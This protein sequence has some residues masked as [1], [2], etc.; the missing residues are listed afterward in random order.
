MQD[1]KFNDVSQTILPII[2]QKERN[3]LLTDITFSGYD[4]IMGI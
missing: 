2:Y 1:F 3:Y 4:D